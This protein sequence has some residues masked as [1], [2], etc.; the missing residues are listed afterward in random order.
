MAN[1]KEEVRRLLDVLRTLMRMVGVS[2][3]EV[4]RRLDLHPSSLTRLFNGQVEAKLEMVLGVARALGLEYRELFEFAYP[5]L[6]APDRM[7]PAARRIRSMLSGLAGVS[8][9][10]PA[11]EPPTAEADLHRS[12]Q[13]I[14]ETLRTQ[15]SP[16]PKAGGGRG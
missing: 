2:N 11:P 6:P 13:E 4:E 5:G 8:A 7:S 15:K 9:P 16:P 12:I 10:Q 3:R 14:L 1:D